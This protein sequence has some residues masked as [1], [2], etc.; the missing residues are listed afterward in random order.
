MRFSFLSFIASMRPISRSS[1]KGPFL[2]DLLNGSPSFP[3]SEA[4]S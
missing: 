4:K 1:T 3:T 2:L